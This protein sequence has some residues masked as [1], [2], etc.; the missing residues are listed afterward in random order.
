[1]QPR[2]ACDS[3]LDIIAEELGIDPLDI[4]LKNTYHDGDVTANNFHLHTCGMEECL[5]QVAEKSRWN[6]KRGNLPP[7]RGIGMAGSCFLSG[8]NVN[9]DLTFSPVVKI[10]Y[11]GAVSL[12]TG[13]TDIGQGCNTTLAMI[14]AEEL[15]VGV[16]DIRVMAGDTD[17]NPVE[18]GS[19][20]SRV[21]IYSGNGAKMAASDAKRQLLEIVAGEMEANPDDLVSRDHRIYVKGNTERGLTFSQAIEL[22]AKK[23]ELPIIGKGHYVPIVG[24]P[25][26]IKGEGDLSPAYSFGASVAE[27]EV[28]PETGKVEV[29]DF[30][31]AHDVG[32]SINPM[33]VEGQLEGSTSM[34]LGY[35]LTENNEINAK[36]GQTMNSDFLSYK[37]ILATEM[38]PVHTIDVE[39]IDPTG[40]FGA[41]ECGEGTTISPAP[42][43][44]NAIYNAIGV[45]IK[46][47]PI[48][49]EKVFKALEE[50]NNEKFK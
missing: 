31:I 44:A 18:P 27:V 17:I 13:A 50:K 3:Q 37:L 11:D 34:G 45:R 43:I 28:D 24:L 10:Y 16:E 12:I 40:P 22:C 15:G 21:T 8:A 36:T 35:A 1:M 48:T 23:K 25:N 20:S 42:A 2:F 29:V 38:P 33:A 26:F 14:V 49:P 4:R 5:K 6:K 46:E 19:Y 30:H 9:P 41:K 7:F 39:T 32:F 47:I